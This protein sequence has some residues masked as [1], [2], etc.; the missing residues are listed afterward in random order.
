MHI[1]V[2]EAT[3]PANKLKENAGLLENNFDSTQPIMVNI[4]EPGAPVIPRHTAAEEYSLES[5]HV[6]D[7]YA[8]VQ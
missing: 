5:H 1:T 6:I 7:G 4:I 2:N 8:V 3:N